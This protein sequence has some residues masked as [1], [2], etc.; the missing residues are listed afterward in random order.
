MNRR[1]FLLAL[2]AA[3][4]LQACNNAMDEHLFA[5]SKPTQVFLTADDQ[6][7]EISRREIALPLRDRLAKRFPDVDMA[8][9][10]VRNATGDVLAYIPTFRD[11]SEFD[12]CR[13]ETRDIGSTAKPIAYAIALQT[14]VVSSGDTFLDERMEFPRLDGP[15]TYSPHNFGDSYTHRNLTL[16]EALAKSSNSVATQVYHRIDQQRLRDYVKALNLP[17][18]YNVNLMQLGRWAVSLLSLASAFTAFPNGGYAAQ[19]RFISAKVYP[20][21]HREDIPVRKTSK[22]FREDVCAL[23]SEGMKMCLTNG[24][25]AF[26]ASDLSDRARGKTGSSQDALSVLQS[27]EITA[28]IWIGNQKSNEDLKM[29]GGRIAMPYLARFFRALKRERPELV[30]PW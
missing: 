24:T 5:P 13:I 30:P 1:Y 29:T 27:R 3:A 28:V 9:V 26:A 21:G 8:F 18:T 14:G 25:G 15:G 4:L 7:Q 19:P 6:L 2:P 10:C 20:D 22:L 16:V 23:V 12:N 11:N 17:L